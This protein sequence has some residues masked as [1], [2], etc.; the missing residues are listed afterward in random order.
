MMGLPVSAFW[1]GV[2]L[3]QFLIQIVMLSVSVPV[4]FMSFREVQLVSHGE[5]WLW[6]IVLFM[7]NLASLCFVSFVSSFFKRCTCCRVPYLKEID[8][9]SRAYNLLISKSLCYL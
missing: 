5:F 2:I 3:D 4:L 6:W 1:A 9:D 7:F 8:E